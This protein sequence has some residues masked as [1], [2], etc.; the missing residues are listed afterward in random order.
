MWQEIKINK[1]IKKKS[2][3]NKLL[4]IELLIKSALRFTLW[5]QEV[6]RPGQ[7]KIGGRFL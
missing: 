3:E 2:I 6:T 7:R 1:Y 4:N 5:T